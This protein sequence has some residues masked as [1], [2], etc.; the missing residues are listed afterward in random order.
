ME[1]KTVRIAEVDV[2]SKTEMILDSSAD[3]NAVSSALNQTTV[4]T[5][6]PEVDILN[7]TNGNSDNQALPKQYMASKGDL[8]TVLNS[9]E[10]V[11]MK[12]GEEEPM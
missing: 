8:T 6:G 9:I 7:T 4:V 3:S 2:E 10:H 11:L 1:P 12:A 5:K